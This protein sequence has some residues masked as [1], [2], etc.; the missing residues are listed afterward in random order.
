MKIFDFFLDIRKTTIKT[1]STPERKFPNLCLI[2]HQKFNP[3][4]IAVNYAI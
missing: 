2:E 4:G 3:T 1:S